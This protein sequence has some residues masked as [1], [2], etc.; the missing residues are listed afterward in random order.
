MS[1]RERSKTQRSKP[2]KYRIAWLE[3]ATGAE[4]YDLSL[5][6]T[7]KIARHAA[8]QMNKTTPTLRHSVEPVTIP[9]AEMDENEHGNME[10]TP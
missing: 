9:T 10:T 7:Y 1:Y 6:N 2:Q 4:G 5:F 8:D 3:P